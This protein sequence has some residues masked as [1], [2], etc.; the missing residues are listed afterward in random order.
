MSRFFGCKHPELQHVLLFC[1]REIQL[2]GPAI[3]IKHLSC[4]EILGNYNWQGLARPEA[5]RELQFAGSCFAPSY[6]GITTLRLLSCVKL[7]GN[8]TLQAIALHQAIWESHFA[9]SCFA[10][11]CLGDNCFEAIWELQFA[12]LW[13]AAS[14]WKITTFRGDSGSSYILNMPAH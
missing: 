6:W 10:P 13:F 14:Y 5:F 3:A 8:V 11:K 7:L 9:R 1:I 2:Q 4:V 12:M